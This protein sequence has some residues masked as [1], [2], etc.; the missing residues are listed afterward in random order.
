MLRRGDSIELP[1]GG[2]VSLLAP[3]SPGPGG[4]GVR[5][6]VSQRRDARAPPQLPGPPRPPHPLRLR[7]GQLPDRRLPERLRHRAR[8]RRDA[9]CRAPLHPRGAHA[10]GLQGDRRRAADPAHRRRLPRGQRAA[11]RRVLPGLAA[12]RPS[13]QRHQALRRARHRHRHDRGARARVRGRRSW[14]RAP[15]RRL[16]R[17]GRLA[18]APRALHRRIP[19]RLARARGLPPRHARGHRGTAACSSPPTPPRW[20][21]GTCGTSSATST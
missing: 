14:P 8:F 18:R 13:H 20:R 5:L 10:P 3:Y 6:W 21:R 4:L 17:D 11:L 12:H 9:Q 15:E 16:D 19:H 7:P 2:R 1:D